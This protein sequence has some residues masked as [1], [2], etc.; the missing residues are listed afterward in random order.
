M[1]TSSITA[2]SETLET[3][4]ENLLIRLA[5]KIIDISLFCE[6]HNLKMGKISGHLKVQKSLEYCGFYIKTKRK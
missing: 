5:N 3:E 1:L 6:K 4:N 2:F